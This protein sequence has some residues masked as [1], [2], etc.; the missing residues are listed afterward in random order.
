MFLKV[1]GGKGYTFEFGLGEKLQATSLI[2]L[3]AMLTITKWTNH[4]IA[5]V[6]ML[7]ITK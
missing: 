1:R 3:V 5:L 6:A 4:L 2:A 7:T